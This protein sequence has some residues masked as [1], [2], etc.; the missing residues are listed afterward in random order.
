MQ[1]DVISAGQALLKRNTD[2]MVGRNDA[3]PIAILRLDCAVNVLY[4]STALIQMRCLRN[5]DKTGRIDG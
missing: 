2:I 5:P 3:A 4:K 1:R